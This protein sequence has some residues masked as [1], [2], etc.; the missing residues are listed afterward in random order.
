MRIDLSPFSL[1]GSE[2]EDDIA[3]E[4]T[5]SIKE[6]IQ[7]FAFVQCKRAADF[8]TVVVLLQIQVE[9]FR[10]NINEDKFDKALSIVESM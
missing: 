4:G 10:M 5:S 2:R 8:T 9:S 3:S 1:N 6:K 7:R